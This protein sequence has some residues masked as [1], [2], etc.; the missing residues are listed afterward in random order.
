MKIIVCLLALVF[1]ATSFANDI[2]NQLIDYDQFQQL[3]ID[4]N[5][6][7]E[8]RRL[9]EEQFITAI[10]SG[11]YIL[12]DARSKANFELRHIKGAINLPFTEFTEASLGKVIPAKETKIL[13]YCNN[14]FLGSPVSFASKAPAASLNLST[15]TSLAAYGYKNVY[16]LGPLL[17]VDKTKIKFEGAEIN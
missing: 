3:V 11:E 4:T 6:V 2:P 5:K 1:S 12:L 13:I 15:Q 16:E 8:Q 17:D 14:N 7:R 10:E 9:T